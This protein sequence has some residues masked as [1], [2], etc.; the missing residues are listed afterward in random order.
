MLVE[1]VCARHWISIK[2]DDALQLID[3]V[4]RMFKLGPPPRQPG[5]P[6]EETF[7]GARPGRA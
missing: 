2:A 1:Q 5:Q 6:Y 4:V 3:E 7:S